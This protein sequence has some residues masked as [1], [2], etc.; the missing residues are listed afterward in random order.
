MAS[1][2][3]V[4][5]VTGGAGFIGSN[6]I[7]HLF[8]TGYSGRILNIDKLTYAGNPANLKGL[9]T[10]PN[11]RFIYEDILNAEG[12]ESAFVFAEECF[13]NK[14]DAVVHFAA[15]S[16]V[17]RSIENPTEFLQTNVVGTQVMLDAARRHHVERFVQIST[18]EVYGSLGSDGAFTEESPIVPNN[19]YSASKAAA[20]MLARA[21]YQ[22]YQFPV[23]ITRSSNNYGPC[24][25][26][27]KLIPLMIANALNGEPLSIFGDG[28]HVRDW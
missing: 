3:S 23:I 21:Y 7:H 1:E 25:F 16:H 24:Q 8:E 12:V 9:E 19:P 22:T 13:D 14:V 17:D 4:I 6:F 18:D 2:S 5:V 20:D 27:E 28:L 11:Y 10:N 26:P 15:E